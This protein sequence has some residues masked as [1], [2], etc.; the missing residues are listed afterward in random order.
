M[1]DLIGCKFLKYFLRTSLFC[2]SLYFQNN[3]VFSKKLT[4][5]KNSFLL[6]LCTKQNNQFIFNG[7]QMI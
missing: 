3:L 7:S 2:W 5:C 4:V 1:A 6:R